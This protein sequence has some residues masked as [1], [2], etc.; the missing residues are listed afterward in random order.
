M[1]ESLLYCY[2]SLRAKGQAPLQK[3][4]RLTIVR[5]Q[6]LF[7]LI[8]YQWIRIGE[9]GVERLFLPERQSPDVFTRT[10]RGYCIEVIQGWCA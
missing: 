3:I 1:F 7:H 9:Q 6:Q 8:A 5:V 4:E 10:L 2:S